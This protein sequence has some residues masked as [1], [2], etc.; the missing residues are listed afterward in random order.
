MFLGCPLC[1]GGRPFLLVDIAI[2]LCH[3]DPNVG[4]NHDIEGIE[5]RRNTYPGKRNVPE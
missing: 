1:N 3:H 5:R 4:I 2:K